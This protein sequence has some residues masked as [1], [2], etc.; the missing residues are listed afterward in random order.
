MAK[1]EYG[2]RNTRTYQKLHGFKKIIAW[3]KAS[4][5]GYLINQAVSEFGPGH[6][7]LIDQMQ[8]AVISASGNIAEGYC[9][10]SLGSYIR[11]CQIARGSL[12]ELGSYIQDCERWGLLAGEQLD[13]ILYVFSGAS[14]FLD[15]LISSLKA[16]QKK[17]DWDKEFWTKEEPA[18][19]MLGDGQEHWLDG[20]ELST[21]FPEGSLSSL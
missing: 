10:S 17:G 1:H 12:G 11:Y 21:E 18:L 19:Y 7:R 5:L 20:S 3:Q 16:K 13:Q 9:Q 8:G 2:G 6:Y 15:R 4:D 14:Y